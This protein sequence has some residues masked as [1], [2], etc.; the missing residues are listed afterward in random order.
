MQAGLQQRYIAKLE[1]CFP[2]AKQGWGR[3]AGR[4]TVG[5]SHALLA[6]LALLFKKNQAS[7]GIQ[8]IF[9]PSFSFLSAGS[10]TVLLRNKKS[11]AEVKNIILSVSYMQIIEELSRQY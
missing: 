6:F 9:I 1:K 4:E 2:T 3:G 8:E 11:H 7:Q 5:S 10:T